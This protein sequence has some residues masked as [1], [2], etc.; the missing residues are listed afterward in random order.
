MN[1]KGELDPEKRD[2][3]R[4]GK[5][6]LEKWRRDCDSWASALRQ[7][8]DA[9][10][11]DVVLNLVA[12]GG[13]GAAARRQHPERPLAA[14][15]RMIRL[16]LHLAVGPEQLHR[17]E[18]DAQV[19]LGAAQLHHRALRSGRQALE[20]ARELAIAGVAQRD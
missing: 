3:F 7:A 2:S 16:V 8:E 5:G 15:D 20:P 11:D 17:V 1:G 4:R 12:A 6:E 9:L 18:L 10:A 13:N 14:V 19:Q